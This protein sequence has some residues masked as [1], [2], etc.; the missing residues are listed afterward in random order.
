MSVSLAEIG[1]ESMRRA[2]GAWFTESVTVLEPSG[3]QDDYGSVVDSWSPLDG[4][5]DIPCMVAP[6]DVSLR[7]K[8]QEFR[9][10]HVTYEVERLRL[11][12]CGYFPEIDQQHRVRLNNRDFSIMSVVHD[13]TQ[14][15]TQIACQSIEPGAA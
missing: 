10:S 15:W 8:S 3:I 12:L 7:L 4:H 11:L 1:G 14:T 2:L 13:P 6:G 9:T 5:E